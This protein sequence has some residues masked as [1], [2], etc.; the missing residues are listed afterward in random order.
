MTRRISVLL[1]LV[2]LCIISCT[3]KTFTGGNEL[4]VKFSSDTLLFDTVFTTLGTATRELRVI[5]PYSK[6][7]RIERIA[8]EGGVNSP[9]RL[10]ID[11]E[12]GPD[13]TGIEL[14]PGDSIFI[15][16]DLIIDPTGE[17]TPL[18]VVD[19][20]LFQTGTNTQFVNLIAWGQ[21]IHLISDEIIGSATWTNDKPW[22]IFNSVFIDTGEV[23]TIEA[24]AKLFFHRGSTMYVAGTL[25]V[26][27]NVDNRVLFSSDRRED[28]FSDVPGQWNGIYF[29][30]VSNANSIDYAIIEN[31]I[32]AIHLGNLGSED[33]PPDLEISNTVIR[34]MTVSGI[35]SLG[36]SVSASNCEISRCG[37]FNLFMALGGSYSFTHCTIVN[38]WGYSVRLTPAVYLSDYY[39]YEETRY[40]GAMQSAVFR[41]TIIYGTLGEELALT[42]ASEETVFNMNFVNSLIRINSSNPI[43]DAY[44][45]STTLIDIDP[46]FIDFNS[47]D[48]RPDTLS[49]L[50]NAAESS[51]SLLFP[52]DIRGFGRMT[53]DGPDIGAYERQPGEVK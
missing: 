27:G 34:N 41:N 4:H 44:D 47:F 35:S 19:S 29:I 20:I 17:D 40:T 46:G 18:S 12:S 22:V 25:R 14:A 9:Y 11:G 30:N 51:V 39:D 15:F 28:Y 16:V 26:N 23:L 1:S 10:N 8:L 6:W 36:G 13:I 49:P 5:N 48:F 42:I 43:W 33:L 32:S 53:D 7:L 37:Y 52:V 2:L 24:G 50:I 3:E 31:G 45:L 21:D 38:Q